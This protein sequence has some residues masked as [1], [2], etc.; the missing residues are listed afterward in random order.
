M[1][2]APLC[3]ADVISF[4]LQMNGE[5]G[6]SMA[7]PAASDGGGDV[8]TKPTESE[9]AASSVPQSSAQAATVNNSGSSSSSYGPFFLEY[10]ML[11]E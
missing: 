7:T 9:D 5:A 6:S 10:S 2:R 4:C 11:A 1:Y 8:R 3:G